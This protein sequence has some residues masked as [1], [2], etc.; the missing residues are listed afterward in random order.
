MGKRLNMLGWNIAITAIEETTL[1]LLS[2]RRQVTYRR[3]K[4][5]WILIFLADQRD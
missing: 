4:L 3:V 2:H 1:P 5:R